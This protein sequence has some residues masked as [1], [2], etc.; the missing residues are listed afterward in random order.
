MSKECAHCKTVN[1]DTADYCDCGC[2]LRCM[3]RRPG[4]RNQVRRTVRPW[5]LV[6]QV[7]T[8]IVVHLMAIGQAYTDWG[9]IAGIGAF[10]LPGASALVCG[11]ASWWTGDPLRWIWLI[12]LG[13][14]VTE[15]ALAYWTDEPD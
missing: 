11:L 12:L 15:L 14:V 7:V 3:E 6:A 13:M 10:F 2:A 1:E 5:V 9:I 4:D 8:G